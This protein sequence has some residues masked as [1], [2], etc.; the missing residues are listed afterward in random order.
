MSAAKSHGYV[1]APNTSTNDAMRIKTVGFGSLAFQ[2]A[3]QA[4]HRCSTTDAR[5]AWNEQVL[6]EIRDP[7][8]RV[9]TVCFLDVTWEAG[10]IVK[11]VPTRRALRHAKRVT[12]P[13]KVKRTATSI[14]PTSSVSGIKRLK[15]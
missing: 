9:Q 11:M 12:S 1:R 5:K 14:G 4:L 3:W 6:H 2:Q 7:I 10:I 15:H 13:S 8:H